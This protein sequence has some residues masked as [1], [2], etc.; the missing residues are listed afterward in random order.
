MQR[1]VERAKENGIEGDY[2]ERADGCKMYDKFIIVAAD[3]DL[4]PYG[5]IIETSRGLGIVLDTHTAKDRTVVDLAT[6]WGK[7]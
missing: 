4:F 2:W 6:T 5:T 7:E 1:I 3:F